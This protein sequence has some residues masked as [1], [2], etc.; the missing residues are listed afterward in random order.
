MIT[1]NMELDQIK[2]LKENDALSQTLIQGNSLDKQNKGEKWG[3][4]VGSKTKFVVF[5]P[6]TMLLTFP[7]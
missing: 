7:S 4:L 5:V 1:V 2:R 6:E 3:R